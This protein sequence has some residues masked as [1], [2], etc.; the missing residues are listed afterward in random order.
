MP[1]DGFT[2]EIDPT[3]ASVV[4]S[5]KILE[6][7]F[8]D[9]RAF[10]PIWARAWLTRVQE[11]FDTSGRFS[12]GWVRLKSGRA[13]H[14][15]RTGRLRRSV[16][17]LGGDI[18][19]E[20]I[21]DP[22]SNRSP[23]DRTFRTPA[24]TKPAS[25]TYRH[26]RSSGGMTRSLITSPAHGNTGP[27]RVPKRRGCHRSLKNDERAKVESTVEGHQNPTQRI[28]RRGRTH[29]RAA[30]EIEALTAEL[31]DVELRYAAAITSEDAAAAAAAIAEQDGGEST[32]KR[33][34]LRRARLTHYIRASIDQRGVDPASVEGE[35]AAAYGCEGLVPLELFGV[36]GPVETRDI[37]PAPDSGNAQ[38]Q[39][40]PMP[41]IWR[42]SVGEYL[43]ISAPVVTTGTAS[44]PVLTTSVTSAPKAKG[45]AAP[46]TAG[47]YTPHT[48][49]PIRITGSIE[50]AKED[51][52]IMIGMEESLRDDLGRSMRDQYDGQIV[53]GSGVAP[54]LNGLLMQLTDPS[55]PATGVEDWPRLVAVSSSAIDGL[56]AYETGDVK[57]LVGVATYQLASATFRGTDGPVSAAAYLE[58]TTGG[59]MSTGRLAAPASH[60]QQGILRLT[61]AGAE[62]MVACTPTWQGVELLSDPY[63]LSHQGK[64]RTTASVLVGG[65]AL[66]RSAAFREVAYRVSAA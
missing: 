58:S 45:Q 53:T 21:Y 2:V 66:L 32:E 22:R 56:Y 42:R 62:G 54:N 31:P 23:S 12:G 55:A 24:H 10:W 40:I 16:A 17:W 35:L 49:T 34:L 61:G 14:L 57:S 47:A 15:T 65:V 50:I 29:A 37:T 28:V 27:R 51:A 5:L 41:N 39:A 63:S 30:S 26:V 18:G 43:G 59:F 19:P 1:N 20:G 13:S 60:I 3:P 8:V 11:N 52:A 36:T 6:D 9:L 38:Q 48:V 44:F 46:A 25:V 7:S 33:A 64:V 4:S